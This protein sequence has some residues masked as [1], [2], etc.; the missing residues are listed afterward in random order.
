MTDSSVKKHSQTNG[1]VQK[2][3]ILPNTLGQVNGGA[4]PL[5]TP[6]KAL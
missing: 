3:G 6:D 5:A 2:H 1:K 4:G